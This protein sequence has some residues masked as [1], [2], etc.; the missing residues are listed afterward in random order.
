MK[1]FTTLSLKFEKTNWAN[2]PEFGLIDSLLEMHPELLSV[3]SGDIIQKEVSSGFGRGDVPSVEQIMRAAIFKE[4]KG[5]DYRE[6]EDAQVDSRI[7]AAFLQLDT[8]SP[9]SF[10]LFQKYISRIKASSL[11]KLLMEI[12][13]IAIANGLEDVQKL[14]QDT[15]T[16]RI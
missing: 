11:Q 12:N 2:N 3:V 16:T 1:L 10:Q 6:L 13:K 5:Y 8:R 4:M 14:P 9:F 15:T 7:C